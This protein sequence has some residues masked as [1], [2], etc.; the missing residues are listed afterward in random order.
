M[1]I[2]PA[3][4]LFQIM[5][6]NIMSQTSVAHWAIYILP[7]IR[8]LDFILGC[9]VYYFSKEIK[10]RIGNY[11]EVKISILAVISAVANI[12]LLFSSANSQSE[13]YSVYVWVLPCMA[14]L[15]SLAL[16]ETYT[17]SIIKFVFE[18]RFAIF[19]GNISFEL[20]LV[21]LLVIQYGQ[22][23]TSRIGYQENILLG[24]VLLL[25]SVMISWLVQLVFN[26]LGKLD[27]RKN[28]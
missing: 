20:F 12:V 3:V 15:L 21:H 26:Y 13:I 28:N 18:N 11:A 22:Q 27:N 1:C 14:L 16:A 19:V 8:L 9:G 10:Q 7:V 25:I 23:I 5:W 4:I 6:C 17:V 24:V 2:V